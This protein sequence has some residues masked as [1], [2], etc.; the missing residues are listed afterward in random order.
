MGLNGTD[1]WDGGES[2]MLISKP[3]TLQCDVA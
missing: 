3:C 2:V 1:F